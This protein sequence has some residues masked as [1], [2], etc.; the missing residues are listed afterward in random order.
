MDHYPEVN[1]EEREYPSSASRHDSASSIA[2]AANFHSPPSLV[3]SRRQSHTMSA[4]QSNASA[5]QQPSSNPP[6]SDTSEQQL[7]KDSIM[8]VNDE[9][10]EKIKAEFARYTDAPPPYSKQQ[11]ENKSEEQTLNMRTHD[12]AK[13]LSRMMG[14]QLVRGLKTDEDTEEKP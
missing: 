12:Y 6:S 11:Y 8:H 10:A 1:V 13:E 3:P 4:T 14:R 5:Q 7:R 9:T 2:K